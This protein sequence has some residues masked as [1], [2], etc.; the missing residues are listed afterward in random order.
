MAQDVALT[1]YLV[2]MDKDEAQENFPFSEH[3][4]AEDYNRAEYG[5]KANIYSVTA[6]LDFSTIEDA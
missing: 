4:D 3:D 2:G 5:G 1:M 6:Y